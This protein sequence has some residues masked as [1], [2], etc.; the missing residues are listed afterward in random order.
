MSDLQR[1]H[2]ST[3]DRKLHQYSVPIKQVRGSNLGAAYLQRKILHRNFEQQA[4]QDTL[5]LPQQLDQS[6]SKPWS[7]IPLVLKPES[8][9]PQPD[10][11]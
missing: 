1:L 11:T 5:H 7:D 4:Y 6:I 10:P 9:H 3:C 8:S 2:V